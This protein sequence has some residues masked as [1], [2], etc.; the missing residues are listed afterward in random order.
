MKVSII[1]AM[2]E[3][4]VIGNADN[5]M[6]WHLPADLKHFRKLTMGKPIVMG[7]KTHESIGRPLPGRHNI[8]ITRDQNY[9]AAGCTVVNS[10]EDSLAAAGDAEE[11]MITGG[12]NIYAQFLPLT[13]C[14]YLTFVEGEFSGDVLFPPWQNGGWLEVSRQPHQA[15]DKNPYNWTFAEYQRHI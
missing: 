3:G 7:R 2:G 10:L 1:V 14:L 15:D 11:L 4:R 9:V 6:P 13:H 5:K 12:A 8:I